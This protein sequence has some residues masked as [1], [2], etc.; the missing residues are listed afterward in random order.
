MIIELNSWKIMKDFRKGLG[1]VFISLFLAA[2][3]GE[4]D[5]N[6][7]EQEESNMSNPLLERL[8]STKTGINFSNNLVETPAINILTYEYF[9]NGGG[10]AI[11]DIDN[12]GLD[13][14]YFTANLEDN[15]LYLNKGDFQFDD[16]SEQAGVTGGRGWTTGVTMVDINNDGYLDIYVC[17]SG[18]FEPENRRNQLF[19]NNGDLTFTEKAQQF[20]LDDP[21]Y[22]TQALFYDY[23]RDN[24]LDMYLL[25]H[26]TRLFLGEDAMKLKSKRDPYAGDKLYRNNEGKFE[27]VSASTGI[28][29]NSLGYGLGVAAGDIINGGWPDLYVTNDFVEPD[30]LYI[31]DQ[32][33]AFKESIKKYTK[34]ISN[35]AM[36]VDIAD[37]NNDG[38]AD[39]MVADMVAEDNY[40]QKTN[41]RSMNPEE[42]YQAVKFGFHYQYM[43]NTLQLNNGNG[44]FSEIS[45]LAGVSNTDWSWAS[46]FA[47]FDND[48]LKDL[49]ITNGF[50]KEFSNKDFVKKRKAVYKENSGADQRTQLMAM[51]KLLDEIPSAAINNYIFKNEGEYNF[52]NRIE[53]WGFNQP[54]FSNGASLADLD[55]DGDLDIVISNIDQ[56]AFIF[57]NRAEELNNS[58]L[59]VKLAGPDENQSGLGSKVEVYSAGGYQYVEH[60]LTRGYQSSL[61][62]RLHFGI[63]KNDIVDSLKITWTDG[64]VQTLFDVRSGSE[65]VLDYKEAS[66]PGNISKAKSKPYLVDD[67]NNTLRHKHTENEYDDFEL[68]VLLPH[69]MSQFGP[70]LAVKDVNNDGLDDIFIGG[71]TGYGASLYIQS[72]SEGFVLQK[73]TDLQNDSIH[74]DVDALFFDA[75]SDGDQDLYVV[76]G[77]NEDFLTSDKLSDRLYTN[78]GNGVFTKTKNALPSIEVSGGV[79]RNIDIDK[80]DNIYIYI[81]I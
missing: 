67:T 21:S 28:I 7:I 69:K 1:P 17:R 13:D 34:H 73:N 42:F 57:K 3:G 30:Y 38:Y 33:G 61:S 49:V 23:D 60:F 81:Y 29:G 14:I 63:E 72:R 78:N 56:E 22:S 8:N 55:N 19:V 77:G 2:C 48:G 53:E 25:N 18:K 46:L 40:R 71:S 4:P 37:F 24:D 11:G 65:I 9:Y 5:K 51:R 52:A 36:G 54:S 27:D 76:S 70:A 26:S 32:N 39:I 44:S 31:N 64:R 43:H 10:V 68:Q 41:M 12:D 20:G 66:L 79:V 58:F 80:I 47:D 59:I 50:R 6:L 16:I 75:D 15:K 74:E 45:Q 35:F 62:D